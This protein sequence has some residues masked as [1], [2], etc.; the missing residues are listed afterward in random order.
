MRATFVIQKLAGLTGGAERVLC[1]ISSALS[2]RGH[3]IE[4]LTFERR[5]GAPGYQ[6]PNVEVTNLF[7]LQRATDPTNQGTSQYRLEKAI[8]SVPD[9]PPLA[10]FKW[11]L[12]HGQFIRRA[13]AYLRVNRPDVVVG[14][15]PAG[16]IAASFAGD[17]LGIPSIASIHSMPKLDFGDGER[18]DRNPVYRRKRLEALHLADRLLVLHQDFI[19]DLPESLR[20]KAGVMPNPVLQGRSI[21]S[22]YEKREKVIIA[23]GRLVKTKRYDM[24][25]SA[26]AQMAGRFPDWQVEIYGEGPEQGA[27]ADTILAHNLVGSVSLKGTSNDISKV[28]RRA[29]VLVHPSQFEGFGLSVAE[30]LSHGIPVIASAACSGVN[31]LIRDGE[32]GFCVSSDSTDT[33]VEALSKLLGNPSLREEFGLAGHH[34]M[35]A[36]G[37]EHIADRW[38][39]MLHETAKGGTT[40]DV[41]LNF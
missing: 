31:A 28:Y 36:Y 17:R 7:P 6:L 41:H 39:D 29:S 12:T 13:E 9:T 20:R 11:A 14:F 3:H 37:I 2:S 33:W 19:S 24:L 10:W 40:Q 27:L 25:V 21:N 30:A 34:D 8:K 16:I 15:L 18:W 32:S 23:V 35:K 22:L 5:S 1:D 26:W 38:V 4:V